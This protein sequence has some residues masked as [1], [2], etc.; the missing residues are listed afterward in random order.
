MQYYIQGNGDGTVHLDLSM[1][2]F[3]PRGL[4]ALA[5]FAR[6]NVVQITVHDDGIKFKFTEPHV[7]SVWFVGGNLDM[8]IH[9]PRRVDPTAFTAASKEVVDSAFTD[10][11]HDVAECKEA[12][13]G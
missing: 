1:C 2:R 12:Y 3:Q 10:I 13:N 6:S 11:K 9:A 5:T 7:I 8:E 4:A